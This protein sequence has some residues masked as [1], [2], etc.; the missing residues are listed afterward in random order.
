MTGLP[1]PRARALDQARDCLANGQVAQAVHVLQ[2]AAGVG[3]QILYLLRERGAGRWGEHPPEGN[4]DPARLQR[5]AVED[6][7]SPAVDE[8]GQ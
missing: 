4:F 8:G 3:F 2:V 6:F 1:S 7:A 5:E